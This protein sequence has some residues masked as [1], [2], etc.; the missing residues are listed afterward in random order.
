MNT[1]AIRPMFRTIDN[2][3]IRVAESEVNEPRDAQALLLCPWPES[4]YA[5]EP[6][7]TRLAA[8]AQLFAVDLPGF[9]HSERSDALMSP[10]AMGEFIVRIADELGL[11]RPHVVGPDIGTAAS[12]FAAA[13]HPR[14]FRSLVVGT[15]GAAVPLQ[16]GGVL[17]EW[18][19]APDLEP[20]RR[21][22]G[23]SIV[24]AV[25]MTFERYTPSEAARADYLAAFAGDRFAESMRYVRAY[26][27]DL[28]LLRDLLGDIETPVQVIAGR[29]DTVV[30]LANAQFLVER[31]RNSKLSV[32]D[33]SHFIWEDAA[34]EYASL[35]TSWWRGGYTVTN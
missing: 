1:I 21:M 11:E 23:R 28:P 14:R 29:Y 32:I 34:D 35:V 4:L 31:L 24:E 18:V 5:Y 9:G 7:W 30:P 13:K 17:K 22:D 20:Y 26:P 19:E 6:T 2:L 10:R 8:K 3:Q 16:L 27:S 25:M 12:L 33:A 15:G